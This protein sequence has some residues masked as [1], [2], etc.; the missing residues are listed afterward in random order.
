MTKKLTPDPP[1]PPTSAHCF[2]RRE[3]DHPP[4]FSVNPNIPAQDALVHIA[5]Y[6][7][8]AY[9]TGSEAIK[10]LRDEGCGMY[11]SN[12]HAIEMA[13][14]LVEALLNSIET[15]ALSKRPAV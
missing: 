5:L 9:A 3:G 4:L 2:T 1:L 7:R 14:G 10:H 11:W 12:L 6:L 8:S 13:E 15:G